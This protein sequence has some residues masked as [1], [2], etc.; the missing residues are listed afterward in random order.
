MRLI[1]RTWKTCKISDGVLHTRCQLSL[2]WKTKLLKRRHWTSLLALMTLWETSNAAHTV[3]RAGLRTPARNRCGANTEQ[4]LCCCSAH[5]V[6]DYGRGGSVSIDHLNAAINYKNFTG[7]TK[8]LL[9]ALA[10]RASNGKG[11]CKFPYGWCFPGISRLMMDIGAKSRDTVIDNLRL[12]E[13]NKA[14]RRERRM[15]RSSKTFVD[16]KVLKLWAYTDDDKQEFEHKATP[17]RKEEMPPVGD[18]E[19]EFL[20]YS[21]VGAIP[22]SDVEE[23]P[24]RHVGKSPT[25]SVGRF[26]TDNSNMESNPPFNSAVATTSLSPEETEEYKTVVY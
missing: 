20:L 21:D 17:T 5:S 18:E 23:L 3:S 24:V 19:W 15:G 16:I 11:K 6:R 26:P 14:I 9:V 25:S 7:N 2:N 22:N 4:R 8:L 12:L 1:V 13:K 10:N